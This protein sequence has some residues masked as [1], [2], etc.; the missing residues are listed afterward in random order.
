[1][2]CYAIGLVFELGIVNEEFGIG[3]SSNP[4]LIHHSKFTIRSVWAWPW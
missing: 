4:F 1:M 2:I 3:P